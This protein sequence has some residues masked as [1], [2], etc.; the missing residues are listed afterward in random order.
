MKKAALALLCATMIFSGIKAMDVEAS[1][2]GVLTHDEDTPLL[3][4]KPK[5]NWKAIVKNVGL[6]G[7]HLTALALTLNGG[8]ALKED[9]LEFEK[10][11]GTQTDDDS[12][13]WRIGL[14][15]SALI[16]GGLMVKSMWPEI[17]SCTQWQTDLA[18]YRYDAAQRQGN[19]QNS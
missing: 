1:D 8:M 3:P 18:R 10:C 12:L 14:F 6:G 15:V 7:L 19:L 4:H 17:K 9:T 2:D 13:G 5:V 16:Q 11:K